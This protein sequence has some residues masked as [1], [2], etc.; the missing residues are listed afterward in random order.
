MNKLNIDINNF[1]NKEIEW[2]M[3]LENKESSKNRLQTE[4][5]ITRNQISGLEEE[6]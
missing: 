1:R 3:E 6:V 2:E 5:N 4:L